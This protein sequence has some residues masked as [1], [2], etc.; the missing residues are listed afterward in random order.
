MQLILEATDKVVTLV[1]DK[2]EVQARVWEGTTGHGIPVHCFIT[3]VAVKE[4][5]PPH[6]YNE[7]EQALKETRKP[8]AE[9]QGIPLRL[10]L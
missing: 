2:G 10:I 1:T 9:V 4:G 5:R 8:S 3:R 6:E 7:F